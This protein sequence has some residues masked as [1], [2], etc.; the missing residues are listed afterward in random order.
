MSST[1]MQLR[2]TLQ[3]LQKDAD[4]LYLIRARVCAILMTLHPHAFFKGLSLLPSR[5][6]SDDA[7]VCVSSNS[8]GKVLAKCHFYVFFNFDTASLMTSFHNDI[9]QRRAI[10]NIC[11][12]AQLPGWDVIAVMASESL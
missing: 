9:S 2:L 11:Q 4:P 5:C 12:A 7:C 6:V 8:T 1:Q 3:R 10:M